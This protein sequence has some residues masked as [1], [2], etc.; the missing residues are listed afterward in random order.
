MQAV[1]GDADA[2][3]RADD[4]ALEAVVRGVAAPVPVEPEEGAERRQFVARRCFT[5]AV[6]VCC[7]DVPRPLGMIQA[8]LDASAAIAA[9]AAMCW[10]VQLLERDA[11]VAPAC[12]NAS[13]LQAASSPERRLKKRSVLTAR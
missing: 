11:N 6:A 5:S 13:V 12:Q 2:R 9:S 10:L 3:R 1:G 4:A 8:G 7:P